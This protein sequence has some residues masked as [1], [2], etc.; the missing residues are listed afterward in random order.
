MSARALAWGGSIDEATV[1]SVDGQR[2]VVRSSAFGTIEA[3]SAVGTLRAGDTVVVATSASGAA[4]VIGVLRALRT[5]D[6]TSAAIEGEV[7]RVRNASG[8]ILFEHRDGTSIVRAPSLEIAADAGDLKLRAAGRIELESGEGIVQTAPSIVL[9]TDGS[10]LALDAD[11]G[12]LETK[13]FAAVAERVDAKIADAN[14]VVGTLRTVA[15]RIKQNAEELETR[16]GRIVERARETYR[17][18]EGLSQTRAGRLRLCAERA[19]HLFG[20]S[21]ELGA[22][23]DVKIKGEKIYLG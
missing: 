4:Y 16:A 14:L 19:L 15:H 22:G 13:I 3:R 18:V 8:E 11:R 7:L 2:A 5:A 23:E 10:E 21:A 6:G 12:K 1:V 17:E 9:S 20:E